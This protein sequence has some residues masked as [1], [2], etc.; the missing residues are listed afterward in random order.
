MALLTA[1]NSDLAELTTEMLLKDSNGELFIA[2]NGKAA[3]LTIMSSASKAFK[4]ALHDNQKAIEA[5]GKN[6]NYI[7][8]ENR[9]RTLVKS[10][11]TGWANVEFEDGQVEPFTPENLDLLLRESTDG[12]A[13]Q[14]FEYVMEKNNFLKVAAVA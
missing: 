3:T 10:V 12:I 9:T 13:G 11:V 7:K 4:K 8:A 5:A 1:K 2:S 14:V 6:D